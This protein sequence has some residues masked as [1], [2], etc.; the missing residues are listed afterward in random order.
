MKT[1]KEMFEELGYEQIIGEYELSYRLD[2][3]FDW[4]YL[5]WQIIHFKLSD[6]TFYADRNYK[7][8]DIDI[9]TF[10]AIHQQMKELHW[11]EE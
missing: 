10:K 8:V 2:S 7:P 11:I 5:Y 6:K 9:S 1:A 4:G 3:M